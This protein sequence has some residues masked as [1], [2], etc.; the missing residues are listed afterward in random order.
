MK[1]LLLTSALAVIATLSSYGQGS[2]SFA[3]ATA[4]RV[5][6]VTSTG[7]TAAVPVG[8]QFTAE[9]VYAPDGTP[10]AAFAA[11][12]TRVG[13][14][15][16]FGPVAGL[17]SGGG[18]TVQSITPPG[19]FGLFQVRVWDTASGSA[20]VAKLTGMYGESGIL[21]VDTGDPTTVPPGTPSPLTGLASFTVTPVP[22]P[23][24]IALGL[25]GVGT[26]L[27]LRRRK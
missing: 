4:T 24:S 12:A 10:S 20:D 21:R 6:Y 18:R 13:A 8:S 16:A 14:T 3:N 1:K 17:F 7:A 26:L 25:L 11:G 23:S 27:M 15:A 5:F 22:E 9:V 2:V 19:G